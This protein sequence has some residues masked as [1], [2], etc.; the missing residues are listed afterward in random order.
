MLMPLYFPDHQAPKVAIIGGGYA[1]LAAMVTIRER[2]PEAEITLIDP[3]EHHLKITH[4]HETFRRPLMEMQL[5]FRRLEQRF[6][7]RF[8]QGAVDYDEDLL[9]LWLEE[10]CLP[11]GQE[12]VDFDYLLWATGAGIRKLDKGEF[13]LDLSDFTRT[14]AP[15]LIQQ[16][17]ERAQS[18]HPVISVVG[19]GATG[20][21]F[22]FELAHYLREHGQ[23]AALRL[24]D[25]GDAPLRQ[26]NPKLGR[27]VMSRLQDLGIDY[28]PN[29]VFESQTADRINL[30]NQD[31]GEAVELS[32]ALSLL[33]VGM[34]GGPRLETN[35]F[36]QLKLK[37][38]VRSKIFAAGD[39]AHY[40]VPGSNALS[41]QTALR[42]GRLAGRNILRHCSRLKLLEPYLHRDLGYVIGMGP[43]DAVGW[44]GLEGNIV[45]GEPANL[46][47]AVVESQYDLLLAGMD[48]YIL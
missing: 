7:I 34:G 10:G 13:I 45:A 12:S 48:T 18:P 36:G 27:Y 38:K 25:A 43:A 1:G 6:G 19:S 24:V 11:L 21:Q 33:F 30:K 35:L 42:K 47:K 9:E 14:P 40:P 28:V 16:Q 37:G 29:H 22:L 32:S 23:P 39:A 15:K 26:F 3:R 5:S 31:T 17:L 2:L 8:L 20:I 44:V 4:L 46:L 41:A